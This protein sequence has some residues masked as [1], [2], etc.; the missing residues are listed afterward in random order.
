MHPGQA[1]GSYKKVYLYEI[2]NFKSKW[3]I[4]ELMYHYDLWNGTR[5]LML[6][7]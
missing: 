1:I 7:L 5:H 4:P 6:T 3:G 2:P